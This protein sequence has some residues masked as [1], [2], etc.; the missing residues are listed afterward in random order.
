[1]G[2]W[3]MSQSDIYQLLKDKRL[4][5]DFSYFSCE[6]IRRML[7]DKG[8]SSERCSVSNQ[9]ARLRLFGYLDEKILVGKYR[10]RRGVYNAYRLKREFC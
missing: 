7:R 4:S 2:K 6:R 1:M 8:L 3:L 9:V 10:K 5:G